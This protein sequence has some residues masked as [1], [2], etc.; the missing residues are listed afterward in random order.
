MAL[1]KRKFGKWMFY[2]AEFGKLK[3]VYHIIHTNSGF[4]WGTA[5]RFEI[6]DSVVTKLLEIMAT[7]GIP[8]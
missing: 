2:F 7:M 8:V 5:L 1:K 4:Q 3:Y 6:A